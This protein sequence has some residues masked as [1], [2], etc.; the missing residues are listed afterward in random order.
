MQNPTEQRNTQIVQQFCAD[1]NKLSNDALLPYFTDD[2]ISG[3]RFDRPGFVAMMDE[4]D[5][6]NVSVV[7]IK[8][9]SRFGRDYLQVGIYTE[10][11]RKNGVRLIALNDAVDT[12]KGDDEFTPFRNIMNEWYARDTSKKIRSAYQAKNLAGKHTSS[13]VPYGYRKDKDNKD[14]WLI[15]EEAAAIVRR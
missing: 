7:C 14:L 9:M 11:L 8:D 2:G 1:W 3:L 4:V 12:A 13:A 6:G 5:A 10:T 15:D